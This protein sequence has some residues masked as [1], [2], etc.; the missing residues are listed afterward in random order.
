[1]MYKKLPKHCIDCEKFKQVDIIEF[2]QTKQ[3][4]CNN[5]KYKQFPGIS[6]N[7]IKFKVG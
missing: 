7:N 2:L 1:M 4:I 5:C 6:Q 3:S